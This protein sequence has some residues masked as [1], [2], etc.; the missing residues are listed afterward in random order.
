[1]KIY[2]SLQIIKEIKINI[3]YLTHLLR[4]LYKLYVKHLVAW[5]IENII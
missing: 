2:L 4:G 3:I 5:N 1:M